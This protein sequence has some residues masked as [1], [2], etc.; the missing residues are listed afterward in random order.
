M[1]LTSGAVTQVLFLLTALGAAILSPQK[2]IHR[3]RL[4]PST[5]SPFGY[6]IAPLGATA[7]G[8]AFGFLVS[9]MHREESG[10]LKLIGEAIRHLSPAQ[11]ILGLLVIGVGP[12]FG[13]EL[14][15]RGY[16]QTRL[17]RRLGRW[18]GILI[19]SLMFGIMHMDLVQGPFAFGLGIYLGYL[20]EQ[21]GSIRPTIVCHGVSNSLQVILGWLSAR[22][23]DPAA[24]GAAIEHPP[25]SVALIGA[26]IALVIVAL[27]VLYIRFR[28]TPPP[29]PEQQRAF[30]PPPLPFAAPAPV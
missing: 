27:C 2:L 13:E 18:W 9:L 30:T 23:A 6:F 24:A 29:E 17:S 5:L 10:T 8:F 7:A 20:A 3:L 22:S 19:T 16:A 25:K 26:G 15:F 11:L 1:L 12:A 28:V 14:L 21:S 4:G